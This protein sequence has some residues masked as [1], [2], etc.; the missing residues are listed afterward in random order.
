MFNVGGFYSSALFKQLTEISC[1]VIS[2]RLPPG[3]FTCLLVRDNQKYLIEDGEE[4]AHYSHEPSWR[5]LFKAEYHVWM[6]DRQVQG[7]EDHRDDDCGDLT[8]HHN[9]YKA[10]WGLKQGPRS[11]GDVCDGGSESNVFEEI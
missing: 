10:G 11:P 7:R 5:V 9:S 6:V 8:H 4:K 1:L 3:I 2:L